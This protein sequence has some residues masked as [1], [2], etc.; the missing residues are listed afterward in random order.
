MVE[1][2]QTGFKG[3]DYNFCCRGMQYSTNEEFRIT[4]KKKLEMC[5]NGLHFCVKPTDVLTYYPP[6]KDGFRNR[7]AKVTA[8]GKVLKADDGKRVARRLQIHD[9]YSLLDLSPSGDSCY[10]ANGTDAGPST[11][12]HNFACYAVSTVA[13]APRT[14]FESQ[15]NAVALNNSTIAK[16]CYKNAICLGA[17]SYA[18]TS[19]STFAVAVATEHNSI[20]ETCGGYAVATAPNSLASARTQLFLGYITHGVAIGRVFAEALSKGDIAITEGSARGVEGSLLV[21]LLRGEPA[22]RAFL[23]DGKKVKENTW[24]SYVDLAGKAAEDGK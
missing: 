11:H 19:G 14:I 4:N 10:C 20:A 9:E 18:Y 12:A 17:N 5:E 15:Q 13:Y 16:S 1:K 8:T 21:F 6:F 23:V 7:Y 3:F 24:Y 22:V 2:C